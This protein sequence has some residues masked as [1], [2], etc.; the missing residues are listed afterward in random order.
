MRRGRGELLACLDLDQPQPRAGEELVTLGRR[1]A[2]LKPLRELPQLHHSFI[3]CT[4]LALAGV[5]PQDP[6]CEFD[7]RCLFSAIRVGVQSS[8]AL[9]SNPPNGGGGRSKYGAAFRKHFESHGDS[10]EADGEQARD[11]YYP[12]A[13]RAGI[14]T[15]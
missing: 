11:A 14:S 9:H 4:G 2:R 3:L 5:P 6:L 10:G 8:G 1:R 7:G 13:H 12:P 15:D